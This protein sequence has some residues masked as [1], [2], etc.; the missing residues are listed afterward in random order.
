MSVPSFRL[1]FILAAF[2]S[3]TLSSNTLAADPQ[4]APSSLI[5]LN[6]EVQALLLLHKF[7]LTPAQLGALRKVATTAASKEV[8]R[9][10]DKG[11]GPVRQVLIDLR[12]ALLKDKR[13]D[14]RIS[15]LEEKLADLKDVE[16]LDDD[17]D[18]T[19]NARRRASDVLRLCTPRQ[20]T[21]YLS[22]FADTLP[23]PLERLLEALDKAAEVSDAEWKRLREDVVDEVSW[24]MG[25]LDPKKAKLIGD[26]VDKWLGQVRSLKDTDFKKRRPELEAAA[27]VF[28]AQVPPTAVMHHIAERGLAEMLSNP[29]LIAAIDARLEK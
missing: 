26:K 16:D 25:G 19:A 23:D 1:R 22:D 3:L 18:I 4:T 27:R 29:R 6:L 7:D 2:L 8:A 24:L 15:E 13:D 9:R 28:V 10:S 21:N 14:D 11:S 17:V 20:V 5:D 12:G